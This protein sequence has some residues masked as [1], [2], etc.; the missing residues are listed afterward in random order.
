MR[1][2]DSSN[3]FHFF[4]L[5]HEGH[6][7]L[8]TDHNHLTS[9]KVLLASSADGLPSGI[10]LQFNQFAQLVHREYVLIGIE[11]DLLKS[12]QKILHSFSSNDMEKVYQ[13]LILV[14]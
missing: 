1:R 13:K 4:V 11:K 9:G 5:H 3:N 14:L 7:T 8:R 10:A 12:I 2:L 6:M